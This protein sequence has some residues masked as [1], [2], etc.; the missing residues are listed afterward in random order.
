MVEITALDRWN[1]RLTK[2]LHVC[3]VVS[4]DAHVLPALSGSS[5]AEHSLSLYSLYCDLTGHV[6]VVSLRYSASP[7]TAWTSPTLRCLGAR[8]LISCCMCLRRRS[9]TYRRARTWQY[10]R[11]L[12]SWSLRPICETSPRFFIA[13]VAQMSLN[14]AICTWFFVKKMGSLMLLDF[15]LA[16]PHT[17]GGGKG[18]PW[19]IPLRRIKL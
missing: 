9:E 10:G 5:L 16:Y 14:C 12:L 15:H 19:C 11:S 18:H 6:R 13:T 7:E 1:Y 3:A 8:V 2:M 17:K 4:E